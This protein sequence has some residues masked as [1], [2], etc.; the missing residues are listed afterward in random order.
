MTSNAISGGLGVQNGGTSFQIVVVGIGAGSSRNRRP[1]KAERRT[2]PRKSATPARPYLSQ[3]HFHFMGRFGLP[4]GCRFGLGVAPCP[5][6]V[7]TANIEL[8]ALGGDPARGLVSA[9]L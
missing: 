4:V 2:G 7:L 9:G 1:R 5:R 8:L 3:L 6:R